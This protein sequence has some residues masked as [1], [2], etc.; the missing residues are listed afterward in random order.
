MG[1]LSRAVVLGGNI[2]LLPLILRGLSSDEY[3]I[4][5]IFLTTLSLA[6]LLDCGF[7]S[8]ISRY[9]TYVLSGCKQLPT[10]ELKLDEVESNCKDVDHGDRKS[11]V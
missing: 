7:A 3:S 6:I 9:Y 5:M 8:V 1:F 10:G 11:V 4:W 2:I